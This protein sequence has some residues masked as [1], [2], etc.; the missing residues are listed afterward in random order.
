MSCRALSAERFAEVY[1]GVYK[2]RHLLWSMRVTSSGIDVIMNSEDSEQHYVKD[3]KK[4][5]EDD[6]GEEEISENVEVHEGMS[7]VIVLTA[8]ERVLGFQ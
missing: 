6:D 8:I 7:V 5:T 2:L 4:R 3:D 1:Q